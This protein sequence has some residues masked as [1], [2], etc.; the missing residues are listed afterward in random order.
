MSVSVMSKLVALTR[1]ELWENPISFRITPIAIGVLLIIMLLLSLSFMGRFDADD[2]T[3]G[4]GLQQLADATA[5]QRG[6]LLSSM[7]YGLSVTFNVVMFFVIA[8]YLVGALYDDRKD[9]SILFWKS[10]PISDTETIASKLLAAMVLI[11]AFYLGAIMLTQL[12]YLVVA[13]LFALG[14]SDVPIWSTLWADSGL[15]KVW[16][17]MGFAFLIYGLWMLPIYGWLLFVSSWAP[18][19]P[20]LI[21]VAVPLVLSFIQNYISF[22]ENLSLPDLNLATLIGERIG[23]GILPFA[24]A[25]EGGIE[26]MEGMFDEEQPMG[27]YSL[28]LAGLV[29]RLFSMEMAVGLVIGLIFIAAAIWFR[30]RA[31]DA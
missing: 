27:G 6:T 21:A 9:R 19:L 1:R 26:D 24:L 31:G 13:S 23:S 28:T 29:T 11:P 3:I 12:L 30:R 15:L 22:R 14:A 4:M 17:T 20:I 5:G 10:L 25:F 8:F 7:L 16:L 2:F 18:R